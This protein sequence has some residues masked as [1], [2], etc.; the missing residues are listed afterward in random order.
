MPTVFHF[1]DDDTLTYCYPIKDAEHQGDDQQVEMV[2]LFDALADKTRLKI[3]RLLTQ[4]QMYLTELTEH[5]EPLTKATIRHHMV[6]LRAAKLVTVHIS[7]H[8][9]YYSLRRETLEEPTRMILRY[10]GMQPANS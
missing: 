9:T 10:L 5:L 8:L 6:R 7:D 2:R 4:R 3:L 1:P